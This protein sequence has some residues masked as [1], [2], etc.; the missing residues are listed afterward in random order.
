MTLLDQDARDAA[1]DISHSLVVTA[2]AGSG[3]TG[4][5][6]FRVL[7]LLAVA[8][9]PEEILAITFTKKAAKEMQERII[10]ALQQADT[11]SQGKTAEQTWQAIHDIDDD[12]QQHT[13]RLAFAALE[14]A[15]TQQWQLIDN[16]NRLKIKTIDSFCRELAVSLPIASGLDASAGTATLPN[17]LYGHAVD[18]LINEYAQGQFVEPMN[19]LLD[20][21]DGN[22]DKLKAQ[23]VTMLA[24]R[25]QWLPLI[26]GLHAQESIEESLNHTLAQLCVDKLEALTEHFWPYSHDV[27]PLTH[28]AAENLK[29]MAPESPICQLHNVFSIPE[30]SLKSMATFWQPLAQL[31]TTTTDTFRKTVNKNTG[32]PPS[33]KEAKTQFTAHLKTLAL[34]NTLLEHLA[35]CKLFPTQGYTPEQSHIINTLGQLLPV[36]VAFLHI[37]FK[38]KTQVDFTEVM[39]AAHRALGIDSE[40]P[41]D[42]NL[43]LDYKLN[44]ILIDE[45]QDTSYT[46]LQLL[47]LLTQA[48]QPDEHRTLFVVGDGMQSCYRF[49][50]ANVGIFLNIRDHGTQNIQPLAVNLNVNFRSNKGVVDWVNNVFSQTFPEHND[51]NYGAVTYEH[52]HAF[53]TESPNDAVSCVGH[54]Y[55]DNPDQISPFT[56][57]DDAKKQQIADII[58]TIKT[59][60]ATSPNAT[61]AVIA[62]AKKYLKEV[63][64]ALK[65]HTINH[66]AIDIDTL[67]ERPEIHD[68]LTITR[69]LHNPHCHTT[70][71]AF[72]R[73]PWCGLTLKELSLVGGEYAIKNQSPEAITTRL[74]DQDILN[75]VSEETRLRLV[76]ARDVM[77][78][79][80]AQQ[81]RVPLSQ[82]IEQCWYSLGGGLYVE[83][84]YQ[85]D[86]I[87]R[88][89][90]LVASNEKAY[91][92]PIW[93]DFIEQLTQLFAIQKPDTTSTTPPVE[94]MTMHKSKGLEFDYVF[95]IGLEGRGKNDDKT[96]LNWSQYLDTQNTLHTLLSPLKSHTDDKP[97]ALDTFIAKQHKQ[98]SLI[99]QNRLMYVACTRAKQKLYVHALLCEKH[100]TKTDTLSITP[101]QASSLLAP[102]W[103]HTEAQFDLIY[104]KTKHNEHSIETAK[105][106]ESTE[107]EHNQLHV[108]T[109]PHLHA[110]LDTQLL[111]SYSTI[112]LLTEHIN[113]TAEK[114]DKTT[115]VS[116]AP[117]NNTDT[118][119]F[120]NKEDDEDKRV[121]GI[122]LHRLLQHYGQKSI[123]T[124]HSH[125]VNEQETHW[126]RWLGT[127]GLNPQDAT[128]TYH[129]TMQCLLRLKTDE[130][131]LWLMSPNFETSHCEWELYYSKPLK[132]IIIDRFFIEN[133]T[134]W[135][136]DYKSAKKHAGQSMDAFLHEQHMHYQDQLERYHAVIAHRYPKLTIK[137][138][139]YFP[140]ESQ[141][142]IT[143][144]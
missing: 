36:S 55:H 124:L 79:Q 69:L 14:N 53:N 118:D 42:L 101:P 103:P 47:E 5:L 23:F 22:L 35:A 130:T 137:T 109:Q 73:A 31:L 135:I 16:P 44:H 108:N 7:K 38:Q 28:L 95:L 131:F 59:H 15:R 83:H 136:I 94:L 49:R 3:K 68:L 71:L 100:D 11:F 50:N 107:N 78:Q 58:T 93:D 43:L 125:T 41:T 29:E 106:I 77:Y 84:N 56:A 37:A 120:T 128:D 74:F 66:N 144:D 18:L 75:S 132:K 51:I 72:L 60:Q 45:F 99:E 26:M 82:T 90:Q 133:E 8:A 52:S 13:L 138:A 96:L 92:L 115:N 40:T 81:K 70:W 76:R 98:S 25:D 102:L 85:Q 104:T 121:A 116:N 129:T 97:S 9:Q 117:F 39:L 54:V 63:I 142:H 6:T 123:D 1:L 134:A 91:E 12:F 126:I 10:S 112:N 87:D 27:L 2:P 57:K 62:K 48:W 122:F 20:H 110:H 127:Q 86:N 46:Q 21:F 111:D 61:I 143:S 88:Y 114:A 65:D 139:L 17:T 119:F 140:F 141:L 30:P 24:K 34:D 67:I 64:A 33:A 19:T 113:N 4:L 105:S 80:F 32:F 89:L